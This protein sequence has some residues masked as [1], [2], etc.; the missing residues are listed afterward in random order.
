VALRNAFDELAI[1]DT[2][3][4]IQRGQADHDQRL[5]WQAVGGENKPLYIGVAPPTTATSD[6]GW[7]IQKFTF[8]AG[9]A[10]GNVPT[11]IQTRTGAWDDRASL[12]W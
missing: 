3:K 6:A 11:L 12:G 8:V 9:P 10:T 5:E 7:T 4:A 2:Q 1:E